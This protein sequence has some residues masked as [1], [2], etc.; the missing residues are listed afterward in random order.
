MPGGTVLGGA[1]DLLRGP[2][3]GLWGFGL[4]RRT[5]HRRPEGPDVA[6]LALAGV[7]SGEPAAAAVAR[8]GLGAPVSVAATAGTAD[9]AVSASVTARRE[10]AVAGDGAAAAGGARGRR[11]G[12]SAGQGGDWSPSCPAA[13]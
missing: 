10:C 12:G 6:V 5:C 13:R 7:G 8:A 11:G 1:G 9:A 3:G 4:P 2:R